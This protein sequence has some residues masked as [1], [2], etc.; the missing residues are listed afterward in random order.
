[1]LGI[2]S[3]VRVSIFI[4]CDYWF[5]VP[6]GR[7]QYLAY[8]RSLTND[9]GLGE[10]KASKGLPS[11]TTGDLGSSFLSQELSFM[12]NKRCFNIFHDMILILLFFFLNVP[13]THQLWLGVRVTDDDILL[14]VLL[15]IPLFSTMNIC[16]TSIENIPRTREIKVTFP[17]KCKEQSSNSKGAGNQLGV[18]LQSKFPLHQS[19]AGLRSCI[20]NK[21]SW[22]P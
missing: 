20:S 2:K 18:L 4:F 5:K 1:M 6:T 13:T 15:W 11:L 22:D 14:Y 17:F 3:P 12:L 16:Y 21:L 19:R 8:S 9:T 7:Q 10:K